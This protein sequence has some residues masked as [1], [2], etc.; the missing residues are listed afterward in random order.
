MP[1]LQTRKRIGVCLNETKRRKLNF[2]VFEELCRNHGYD[3]T[4]VD[5]TKCLNNQ[6]PFDLIIHKLSDLLVEAGQ[7]LPSHH[8]VQRLQA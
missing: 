2:A 5:L 7:D 6:G 8:L 3:V 1:S 4:E